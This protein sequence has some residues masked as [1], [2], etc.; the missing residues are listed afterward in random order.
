MKIIFIW[1]IACAYESHQYAC[2]HPLKI[3]PGVTHLCKRTG[4]SR[5][6]KQ[7]RNKHTHKINKNEQGDNFKNERLGD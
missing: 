1:M 2:E 6:R 4:Y 7:F 5:V 3:E